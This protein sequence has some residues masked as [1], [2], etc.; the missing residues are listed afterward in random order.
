MFEQEL[1]A[2][3]LFL[4]ERC[5]I[6]VQLGDDGLRV[7]ILVGNRGVFPHNFNKKERS[8]PATYMVCLRGA[9]GRD[10]Y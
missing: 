3:L 4:V 6:R 1:E 10:V 9:K 5:S 8:L 7:E 2:A